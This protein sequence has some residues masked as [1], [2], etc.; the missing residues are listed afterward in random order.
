MDMQQMLT[1]VQILGSGCFTVLMALLG[2]AAGVQLIYKQFFSERSAKVSARIKAEEELR[3]LEINQKK[4]I[5]DVAMTDVR[6]AYQFFRE[7]TLKDIRAIS[8]D[9]AL[10]RNEITSLITC[11]NDNNT[12]MEVA[13]RDIVGLIDKILEMERRFPAEVERI[14]QQY[15]NEVEYR[16]EVLDE[17]VHTY[18]AADLIKETGQ[19]EQSESITLSE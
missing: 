19:K 12:N 14:Y 4:E 8:T 10:L 1:V 18:H 11:V 13:S 6:E 9:L 7:L 16:L 15:K 5:V 17:K 3:T 2:G